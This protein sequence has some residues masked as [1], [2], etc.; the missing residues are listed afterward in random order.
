M[1]I[2]TILV[3]QP[4]PKTENSPYLDLAEKQK[5]KIDFRPFIKVE[6]V[7]AS[8]FRKEKVNPQDFNAVILS[9]RNAVDHYF[10]ICEEMRVTIS[11]EMKYFCVSEA[12]AYYLQKYV[13]YRK[14]KIY[15]GKQTMQ[16]LIPLMKRHKE[17]Q[18]FLPTSDI[19]KP[20][21]PIA[22][23]AAGLNFTRAIL[24]RTVCSDLSDLKDV[25]YDILVF[26]SPE[27]IRSLFKNFPDFEQK[28]TKIAVFGATTQ[29]AA[30]EAGLRLDIVA[31]KPETPSMTMALEHYIR[32][33][34]K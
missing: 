27:G 16:D 20:D 12:V 13:I 9:S 33:Y 31:P 23:D 5:L 17:E 22:L 18:F 28:E 2:K 14:R 25:S 8:E 26:F 29:K 7:S 10:R 30:E 21:V 1:K 15:H 11:N 4:E 32:E 6:G 24:Y 3:S 19:L 34:N